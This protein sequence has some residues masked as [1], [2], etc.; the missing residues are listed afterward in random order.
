MIAADIARAVRIEDELARRGFDFW[1]KPRHNNLGTPCPMCGGT[2]RFSINIKKQVWN[3]RGCARGGDVI[4]LVQALSGSSFKEAV[5]LLAG[6]GS[7]IEPPTTAT[8]EVRRRQALSRQKAAEDTDRAEENT[9]K[10]GALLMWRESVPEGG[11]GLVARYLREERGIA[12]SREDWAYLSPRVIRFHPRCPF[13]KGEDGKQL[14]HP[15]MVCLFRNV[16]TDA[17]QAVFRIAL[18]PD[19]KKI[20]RLAYGPRG[21]SSIAGLAAIKIFD[22]ADVDQGLVLAEGVET[23]LAAAYGGGYRPVWAMA[24]TD[25]I[26]AFP[27]LP[28]IDGFTILAE[29][30][31]PGVTASADAIDVCGGRWMEAGRDVIV[32][33]S[34]T[35]DFNDAVVR[36]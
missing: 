8:P 27:V 14:Y 22:D 17:E 11:A 12:L 7:P 19:G 4:D 32:W 9:R 15:A 10:L 2:D 36:L 5:S 25:G 21:A 34:E 13:G 16:A 24:G 35:G 31:K 23:A 33:R 1:L 29:K 28:G 6:H 26:A 18:T 3:C 20:G 30:D